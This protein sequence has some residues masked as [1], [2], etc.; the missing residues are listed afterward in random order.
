[1][2]LN[3]L[4]FEVEAPKQDAFATPALNEQGFEMEMP[5]PIPELTP[6]ATAIPVPSEAET[7][8]ES[9]LSTIDIPAPKAA[10]ITEHVKRFGDLDP[11][12]IIDNFD[13]AEKY[14]SVPDRDYW[15]QLS[16]KSPKT[17]KILSTP[18]KM[19]TLKEDIDKLSTLEQIWQNITT[20]LD[21]GDDQIRS[22]ELSSNQMLNTL[23]SGQYDQT[24]E[25]ELQRLDD[26]LA[27]ITD[28]AP[29]FDGT[30]AFYHAAQQV[31]ILGY[32]ALTAAK[33]A[34]QLGAVAGLTT[35]LSTGGA[36]AIPGAIAGSALGATAGAAEAIIRLEGGNAFREFS[37]ITDANGNRIDP[38][39]A[40]VAA[41]A[42]GGINSGLELFALS[43][44]LKTFPGG[45]QALDFINQ[46]KSV[47]TELTPGRAVTGA[48]KDL[49]IAAAAEVAT[50]VGQEAVTIAGREAAASLSDITPPKEDYAKRVLGVVS[51]TIQS[52]LLIGSLGTSVRI[53]Q[54]VRDSRLAQA[55]KQAYT[56]ALKTV[57]EMKI[58][59]SSP[60]QTQEAVQDLAKEMGTE[61]IY[62]AADRF[63][64]YFQKQNMNLSE[65][66]NQVGVDQKDFNNAKESGGKIQIDFA[67]WATKVAGTEHGI[68]LANDVTNRPSMP[69]PRE[70]RAQDEY[71]TTLLQEAAK[72]TGE[73]VKKTQVKK[74]D[75]DLVYNHIKDVMEKEGITQKTELDANAK[76]WVAIASTASK[77]RGITISEWFKGANRPQS[78]KD[79]STLGETL[80]QEQEGEAA[81]AFYSKIQRTLEEKMQKKMPVSSIAKFDETGKIVS[82][83]LQ[84]TKQ[85][86]ADYL[87]LREFLADKDV[88]S[89]EELL[90]YI[91]SNT[92]PLVER[93]RVKGATET[94]LFSELEAD[95]DQD[96]SSY[97]DDEVSN[98]LQEDEDWV[99]EETEDIKNRDP[100]IS[101]R[102]LQ[103]ELEERAIARAE[104]YVNSEDY[105]GRE[106][107]TKIETDSYDI[108]I[109]GNPEGS[110]WHVSARQRFR[111]D[112]KNYDSLS[113]AKQA[114]LKQ[115]IKENEIAPED[116]KEILTPG[117]DQWG[118]LV[119]S[120]PFSRGSKESLAGARKLLKENK[121]NYHAAMME[122]LQKE[123]FGNDGKATIKEK[124]KW[125]LDTAEDDF[126]KTF[127][128]P[129]NP[130]ALITVTLEN[131]INGISIQG[132]EVNGWTVKGEGI[133]E[134][135]SK[136]DPMPMYQAKAA[137]ETILV[138]AGFT[139]AESKDI[140]GQAG[141]ERR[142]LVAGEPKWATYTLEGPKSNYTEVTFAA[143]SN[144]PLMKPFRYDTH[145]PDD[146]M[147]FHYRYDTR[148]LQGEV[149][150]F[151]KG[152]KTFFIEEIQSDVHEQGLKY[153]YKG[154]LEENEFTIINKEG[155]RE[156][157]YINKKYDGHDGLLYLLED[158]KGKQ[159]EGTRAFDTLSNAQI[160]IE[161]GQLNL[162]EDV[163]PKK[164][165]DNAIFGWSGGQV[166]P[167]A[168]RK[169]WE[170]AALKRAVDQ[171][172]SQGLNSISWTT[173]RQQSDR[174][175]HTLSTVSIRYKKEGDSYRVM[176][177]QFRRDAFNEL[178]PDKALE[179]YFPKEAAD[180]IRSGYQSE[181]VID[182]SSQYE[183]VYAKKGS[184][185][186]PNIFI[187]KDD[188]KVLLKKKDAWELRT[189]GTTMATASDAKKL[190]QL[191]LDLAKVDQDYL[192]ERVEDKIFEI[193][194]RESE[195]NLLAQK[196]TLREALDWALSKQK[197][198]ADDGFKEIAEGDIKIA[199]AG[200]VAAYDIRL[201]NIANN[202][203]KKYG[204]R[205]VDQE[206][207]SGTDESKI[208]TIRITP[209]MKKDISEKGQTLFQASAYHGSPH[210]F[211]EFKL[212]KIGTGEGNQAYG[213]GLYFAE[214]KE[215]AEWYKDKLS[216]WSI[217]GLTRQENS[218]VPKWIFRILKDVDTGMVRKAIDE[219][220]VDFQARLEEE[221]KN[222]DKP[223]ALQPW[224]SEQKIHGLTQVIS[225]L[226]KINNEGLYKVKK[227]GTLYKVE[228]PESSEMLD[229]DKP[230]NQQNEKVQK[231]AKDMGLGGYRVIDYQPTKGSDKK[232]FYVVDGHGQPIGMAYQSEEEA[233]DA[234]IKMGIDDSSSG[235]I[236]YSILSE[237][238][239]SQESASKKL[240]SLGIPGIK[241][242]DGN[243]RGKGKGHYNFV[244]FDDSLVSIEEKFY[245]KKQGQVTISQNESV[246]KLFEK[247]DKSTFIHESA[248]IWFNDVQNYVESGGANQQQ[249]DDFNKLREWAGIK[250]GEALTIE[251]K[252]KFARAWEAYL[253]E[254]KA[255]S[256]FLR[257]AFA[258]FKN[259][260][261]NIY[262]SIKGTPIDVGLND[263][264]RGIF[265]RML[266]TDQEIEIARGNI[267]IQEQLTPELLAILPEEVARQL[268]QLRG[269]AREEATSK[270]LKPQME[271]L[272]EE[273]KKELE[274]KRLEAQDKIREEVAAMPI[275]KAMEEIKKFAENFQLFSG[276]RNPKEIA[277]R[278]LAGAMSKDDLVRFEMYS[279]GLGYSSGSQLASL[280]MDTKNFDVEVNNRLK[281]YMQQFAPLKDKAQIKDDALQALHS[282]KQMEIMALEREIFNRLAAGEI[283]AALTREQQRTA[284]KL[285]MQKL[286]IDVE[287]TKARAHEILMGKS[288]K[289]ASAFRV[290]FTAERNA[291]VQTAKA[292]KD[293]KYDKAAEWKQK[294]L[295]NH[296]LAKEAIKIYRMKESGKRYL[297]KIQMKDV[298]SFK[299]QTHFYQV[300]D[301]LRRFGF[302]RSDYDPTQRQET[303]AAWVER[304]DE[305]TLT[306]D[307]EAQAMGMEIA[308]NKVA[309]DIPEWL[310]NETVEIAYNDLKPEELVNVV[311][312]V[313]NI[314]HAANY[315]DKAY[316]LFDGARISEIEE[317]LVTSAFQ[318]VPEARRHKEYQEA[319]RLFPFSNGFTTTVESQVE[320]MRRWHGKYLFSLKKVQTA[321]SYLDKWKEGEFTKIWEMVYNAANAES[322]MLRQAD[323]GM[324]KVF[325]SYSKSELSQMVNEKKYYKELGI[326]LTKMKMI[327]MALNL[328]N[329]G[330]RE[331]L[332]ST[333]PVG[334]DGAIAWDEQSVMNLLNTYLDERDW[335]LVQDTW[336]LVNTLWP[337]LSKVHT[338]VTGFSPAKVEADPIR[339]MANGKEIAL[340]G[341]YWP[342][343]QDPRASY[344]AEIRQN[345]DDPLYTQKNYPLKAATKTGHTEART[346]AQYA[347][348]LDIGILSKH[349]HEVIHDITFRPV[350]IDLRRLFGSKRMQDMLK[351]TLGP[352]GHAA[353]QSWLQV[354][355]SG[356]TSQ[357][358]AR[359]AFDLLIDFTRR[360]TSAMV[361]AFKVGTI[362]QN[363]SNPI[364]FANGIEGFGYADALRGYTR[365]LWSYA[366]AALQN[367][368]SYL[369]QREFV[370]SKSAFL[371]DRAKNPDLTLAE[372]LREQFGK[373]SK[374]AEFAMGLLSGSD[375]LTNVPMWITAYEKKLN[376]GANEKDAIL[377]A[378]K[379]IDRT[380]GSGRKY[381]VAAI[382]RGSSLDRL[383]SMFYSFMNTETNRWFREVGIVRDDTKNIPR[384]MGFLASRMLFVIAS[385]FLSGKGGD[386]DDDEEEKINAYAAEVLKYP[387][388]LFPIARDIAPIL[389]DRSLGLRSYG[390]RASPALGT[391]DNAIYSAQ[392][393]IKAAKDEA[394]PEEAAEA[395]ARTMALLGPFPYPD[396]FNAWAFNAWDAVA[397]DMEWTLEDFIRRRK[398]SER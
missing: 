314:V 337:E 355:G 222:K 301:I 268:D 27:L 272:T 347:I 338:E 18:K 345:E 289:E 17:T 379:L 166:A 28:K 150:G 248:H 38:R 33:R 232:V 224:I 173:G 392:V 112:T 270:L 113:E 390:Y 6:T 40:A 76:M 2:A 269:K 47:F 371:R 226:E 115:L 197:E 193:S 78:S 213:W 53:S 151:T 36:G 296:A 190:H 258:S 210:R 280:M 331:K 388:A 380:V 55:N 261:I 92:I 126:R 23:V 153:G 194:E 149:E 275:Y 11:D 308:T 13:Q 105:P 58:L 386:E 140:E 57:E 233:R 326:D 122:D 249:V 369:R 227:E 242:L 351:T 172:V 366:S 71:V 278:Y 243:S 96:I 291:A 339:V 21:V 138:N 236:L 316:R 285:N 145:F 217:E 204:Q 185:R 302:E 174:Y 286:K 103:A 5:S 29:G 146:N 34:T 246:I 247:K 198:K 85:E 65:V 199:S 93:R 119:A 30:S 188:E 293:K 240:L 332:F 374:V 214:N 244:I 147:I 19:A 120:M 324:K 259:W 320:A 304:M 385:T 175:N 8:A 323:D 114:V 335:K 129:E 313:K 161:N 311:N 50:E 35:G 267:E 297:H 209:E 44:V 393:I 128:D 179:N 294:Q 70:A 116:A 383:F 309:I 89:K 148:E 373:D 395:T 189:R 277:G 51:P 282:D 158:S 265:D 377:Y 357:R 186:V 318:N 48:I 72:E 202:L 370:H 46:K 22:G 228:I 350:V 183:N 298:K 60:E 49:L 9:Y 218:L 341:G 336:D 106:Y 343:S 367:S 83:L 321:F 354:V 251:A 208:H 101:D 84:G 310:K 279:E 358:N 229:W 165:E 10:R 69:T 241:F 372:S 262:K 238:E 157:F 250:E 295:I 319:K 223:D 340:S 254:G 389:I 363:F 90:D 160:V 56:D 41:L 225:V 144:I 284:Q 274:S 14:A 231:L 287:F 292:L 256:E 130:K 384:F 45:Q 276:K 171:A 195:G 26:R 111:L 245:Q 180:R 42:V 360:R 3:E 124:N 88:V 305:T 66:L 353:I 230:L 159:V 273:Y 94:G 263:E 221:K 288:I 303:L 368:D 283:D 325:S 312:A 317:K 184:R 212:N 74:E 362:L 16:S 315:E 344:T 118:R 91:K 299:D 20:G 102:D 7:L 123:N 361:I 257:K 24:G 98:T 99:K 152:E 215:V 329:I 154:D 82:G 365:A 266:A 4:G 75:Y 397:N 281:A 81:P 334:V 260:L 135:K 252:E 192:I 64:T 203:F 63:E 68:N 333:R 32:T 131:D 31:P 300:A 356:N 216:K 376:E 398:K 121:Q 54:A 139:T 200:M 196:K 73:T 107:I 205:V 67:T 176:G 136:L 396:Q 191:L 110:Y 206:I 352:E 100:E 162:G 271:E 253:R 12:F 348:N 387:F 187:W 255:P 125:M 164:Y 168:F 219:T 342:L 155:K 104:E 117:V 322:E 143:P 382:T 15:E 170:E 80:L 220:I 108:T 178:I 306:L 134:H 327:V 330:N 182:E 133:F 109:T 359:S 167:L 290:Y 328:G 239:G 127:S 169:N 391:I 378:D 364:L 62:I 95:P 307:Q 211:D 163:F 394:T 59:A 156:K 37:K 61:S 181:L 264:I 25:E 349:M 79:M 137:A 132:N 87:K 39:T 177:K 201:V 235:S 43:K 234:S 86:E 97:I 52:T 381:D 77:R 346:N 141:L 1:M 142:F 237:K 375:D 207:D